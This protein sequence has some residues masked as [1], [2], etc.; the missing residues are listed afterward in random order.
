LVF[1]LDYTRYYRT[2]VALLAQA[3]RCY[4]VQSA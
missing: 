2:A 1:G 3:Q 4:A